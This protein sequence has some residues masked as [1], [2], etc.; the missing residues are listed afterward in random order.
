MSPINLYTS[1]PIF[2]GHL[3]GIVNSAKEWNRNEI[4]DFFVIAIIPG[5]VPPDSAYDKHQAP[6]AGPKQLRQIPPAT[7]KRWK[8]PRNLP[9]RSTN[10]ACQLV[11]EDYLTSCREMMKSRTDKVE[12]T[13][14]LY[15]DHISKRWKV[16]DDFYDEKQHQRISRCWLILLDRWKKAHLAGGVDS[17]FLAFESGGQTNSVKRKSLKYYPPVRHITRAME[18]GY[19]MGVTSLVIW[20]CFWLGDRLLHSSFRIWPVPPG[21]GMGHRQRRRRWSLLRTMDLSRYNAS[22]E[23]RSSIWSGSKLIS[24]WFLNLLNATTTLFHYAHL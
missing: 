15:Q 24:V 8:A 13:H 7:R 12:Q 10:K 21:Y 9:R 17:A 2:V 6:G 1:Q 5:S 18:D 19:A 4:R 20:F 23:M 22:M 3:T 11:L 14:G 16:D